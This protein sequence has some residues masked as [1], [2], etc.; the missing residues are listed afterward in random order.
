MS[1]LAEARDLPS[2]KAGGEEGP[3][4]D[5]VVRMA[6]ALAIIMVGA[7]LIALVMKLG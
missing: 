2:I 4:L 5:R 3:F 6:G 1:Q 7:S